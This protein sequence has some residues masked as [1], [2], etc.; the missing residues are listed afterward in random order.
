MIRVRIYV[1]RWGDYFC[2]HVPAALA[3]AASAAAPALDEGAVACEAPWVDRI[4]ADR[5]L[6]AAGASMCLERRRS[7][8]C[9]SLSSPKPACVVCDCVCV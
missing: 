4:C 6:G 8:K 3:A 9:T 2:L 1:G 7:I 5:I